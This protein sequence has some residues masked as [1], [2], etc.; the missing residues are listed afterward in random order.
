MRRWWK[1]SVFYQIYPRSFQDSNGD[2]VGDLRGI[3][4]R[5]DYLVYL[6]VDAIWLCP[7]YDS[8]NR[9][10]GY[11]IRD[12]YA[13]LQD[14][15]TMQDMMDL[16]QACTQHGLKIIMDLVA[17]HTS[18]ENVWFIESR[19]SKNSSK[20]NWYIWKEG[21]GEAEPTNMESLFGGSAWEQDTIT[22]EYY[23][24]LFSKHQPDLNL[25][26]P[27]VRDSIYSMMR[28]WLNRGISG[29]RMDA[30]TFLKK[31]QSYARL[32]CIDGRPY[33][34][35]SDVCLN[36]PGLL[37]FLHEMKELVLKPYNS[38]SV[39]E[40]P[41]I[42][43]EQLTDFVDE[44]NG[45]FDMII[46]FDHVDVD[47][48]GL[49]KGKIRQWD[50]KSFKHAFT[51]WQEAAIPEGW[52]AL[53]LENHDQVRSVSKF[54]ND[55]RYRIE[56]AK[57]LAVWFM[58]MRGTP[59]IY[60]GQEIGMTNCPFT[61]IR[62]YR[63]IDGLN[64]YWGA[65]SRGEPEEEALKYLSIKGRDHARTPM[66]WSGKKNAGF[67]EGKPWI[68]VNP[69]HIDINVEQ[70]LGDGDSILQFYRALIRLR[71]KNKALVYG[72]YKEIMKDSN[73]VGGYVRTYGNVRFTVI[74]NFTECEVEMRDDPSLIGNKTVLSNVDEHKFGILQPYEAIVLR[75]HV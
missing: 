30:I 41:G 6:G 16:I 37:D 38:V 14:F 50:L 31:D 69:N 74:C 28:W 18:D 27:E 53:Y 66:Q 35:V 61:S 3:I 4:N 60:Q 42:L 57:M 49:P 19:L 12:Y 34:L 65:I 23:L 17:N 52:I 5:L 39:A 64:Y 9:D 11:D 21:Y 1:E 71:R 40:A 51:V 20:R 25:E 10:G 47:T 24:H 43:P 48:I 26:N 70:S 33:A 32:S 63:D 67:S 72:D 7:V 56:S 2:G 75:S 22:G 13:I 8:P 68:Q 62:E 54:G 45:V 46:T 36:Q 15:G 44:R 59:F 73:E 29:F 58:L 55:G